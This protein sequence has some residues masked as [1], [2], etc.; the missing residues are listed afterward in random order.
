[1]PN[2][3]KRATGLAT[4][5]VVLVTVETE[6][7]TP[8][9][10]A[11][12]TASKIGIESQLETKEAIKLIIKGVLKAQKG[13]TVTLTGTTITL[14]D[15]VFTPELVQILQGGVIKYW[16]N[17]THTEKSDVDEGYGIAEY[18]PPLAGEREQSTFF[19]LK[20]YSAIYN[21]AA[22]ITGYECATYPHCYGDPIAMSSEDD[23]F[24]VP[25]YT[26]NSAPDVGE[27]PYKLNYVD[28]LPEVDE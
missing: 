24:R 9:K 14:T 10:F 5:D 18:T 27:A 4:I 7:A 13:K 2:N 16:S 8:R 26:I 15:N 12:D 11:L 23:V 1:M 6:E 22:Q 19:T 25:E 20:A 3:Y 17:E 28:V 21:A